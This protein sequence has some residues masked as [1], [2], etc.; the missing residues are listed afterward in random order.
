[1]NVYDGN[2]T[3]AKDLE[4]QIRA[5]LLQDSTVL[6]AAAASRLSDRILAIL[7]FPKS[8]RSQSSTATTT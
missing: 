3:P 6:L 7:T 1:M 4:T 8:L 2:V 5:A